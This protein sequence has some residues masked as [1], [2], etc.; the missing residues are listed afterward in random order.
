VK[1]KIRTGINLI[2]QEEDKLQVLKIECHRPIYFNYPLTP[3]TPLISAFFI[4]SPYLYLMK[5]KTMELRII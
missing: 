1:V 2:P 5:V 4:L 3:H